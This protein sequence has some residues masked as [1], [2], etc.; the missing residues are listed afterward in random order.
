MLLLIENKK[1]PV[2]PIC[3]NKW[4]IYRLLQF[5]NWDWIKEIKK[6]CT[7]KIVSIINLRV[8]GVCVG[9]GGQDEKRGE[10]RDRKLQ[11]ESNEME[12]GAKSNLRV[13]GWRWM[14][15]CYVT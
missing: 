5:P 9:G 14:D 6:Q 12:R 1:K 8:L 11:N 3:F 4:I 10:G 2:P 7:G 15:A 13:S